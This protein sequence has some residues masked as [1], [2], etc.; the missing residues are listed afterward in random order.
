MNS[1]CPTKGADVEI[2]GKCPKCKEGNQ[3]LRKSMYGAFIA[4]DRFPK[5]FFTAKL[6]E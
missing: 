1:D 2:K 5:C 6:P 3:M 4:C